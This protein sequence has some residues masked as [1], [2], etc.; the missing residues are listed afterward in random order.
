MK[1]LSDEAMAAIV[2]EMEREGLRAWENTA[3]RELVGRVGEDEAERMIA[4][5]DV[6]MDVASYW[7]NGRQS[8][9]KAAP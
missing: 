6:L 7:H 9:K 5:V 8:G 2:R 4:D 1:W 3:W